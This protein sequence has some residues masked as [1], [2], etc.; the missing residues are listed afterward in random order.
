[1]TPL[2]KSAGAI[3]GINFKLAGAVVMGAIAYGIWPSNPEWWGFGLMSIILACGAVTNVVA[4]IRQMVQLY[5]R[6]KELARYMRQGKAPKQAEIADATTLKKAGM[7]D[8]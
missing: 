4:A 8:D 3:A 2:K 5:I 1:M 7:L 6:D